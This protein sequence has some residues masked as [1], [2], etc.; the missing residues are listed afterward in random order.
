MQTEAA[1]PPEVLNLAATE[2]KKA[3]LQ[4]KPGRLLFLDQ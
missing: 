4:T 3:G 1:F 2:H